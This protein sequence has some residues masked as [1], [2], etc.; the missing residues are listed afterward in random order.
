MSG[1]LHIYLFL[2]FQQPY[3]MLLL[4]TYFSDEEIET[5]RET[6]PPYHNNWLM[7]EQA[8]KYRCSEL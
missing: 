2:S 1:T 7:A 8:F 5:E 4:L 6:C 3:E